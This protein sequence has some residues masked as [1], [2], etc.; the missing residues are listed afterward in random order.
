MLKTSCDQF[1]HWLLNIK[2]S[3]RSEYF[4]TTFIHH[5]IARVFTANKFFFL[6]TLMLILILSIK[7]HLN[8]EPK[9]VTTM[10]IILLGESWVGRWWFE[11]LPPGKHF[12][13]RQ[14][15]LRVAKLSEQFQM[16]WSGDFQSYKNLFVEKNRV[17]LLDS[18]RLKPTNIAKKRRLHGTMLMNCHTY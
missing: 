8:C 11:N 2:T 12:E 5:F 7:N 13:C 1:V 14:S 4:S 10:K 6:D 17:L 15:S 16:L 9:F 3:D 18:Q